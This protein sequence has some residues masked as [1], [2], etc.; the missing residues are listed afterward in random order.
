MGLNQF[1][2][3]YSKQFAAGSVIETFQADNAGQDMYG[4][5]VAVPEPGVLGVLAGAG[6]LAIRRRRVA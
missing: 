6:L 5:V 4:L 1:F 2:T 3:V